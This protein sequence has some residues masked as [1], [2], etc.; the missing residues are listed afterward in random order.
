MAAAYRHPGVYIEE[1]RSGVRAIASVSTSTT[2]FIDYF[3]RGPLGEAV[4]ITSYANF[5]RGFGGLHASSPGSYAIKQFYLNGGHVALVVRV[6]SGTPREAQ[7]G[8]GATAGSATRLPLIVRAIHP[9]TWGNN[10][11]VA[12]DYNTAGGQPN[13]FNL[14]VREVVTVGGRKQV[15]HDEVHRNLSMDTASPRYA[16][17][18]VNSISLLV[19][20][21]EGMGERGVRPDATT[22]AAV[23]DVTQ[24]SI[25]ADPA[26]GEANLGGGYPN[27]CRVFFSLGDSANVAQFSLPAADDGSPPDAAALIA[28][29]SALDG[30]APEIFNLLCLPAAATLDAPSG[31][32]DTPNLRAVVEAAE[33]CCLDGRAFLIVDIPEF[34]RDPADMMKWMAANENF[35]HRNAA[36]YYPRL[37][38]SDPL[39]EGRTRNVGASGTMAGVYAATDT[40][41]GVWKAPAGTDAALQ[42][43]VLTRQIT[44]LQNGVLNPLGI[45]ALRTFPT[46]GTVSWGARTLEGADRL[47]SEWRYI[48]VRRMALFI[49][50]SL[51]QGLK[52][53]VF[54]PNDEPLWG[55]IRLHAGAFMQNLFRQGAFQGSSP[56][57]AYF[58]KCDRETTT[59][60]DIDRG[61]VNVVV[62]FAALKPAEFVVIQIQ[63]IAEQIQT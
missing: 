12:I 3:P 16:V 15:L 54:E 25:L 27:P 29:L 52:W 17:D 5:E 14:V 53:V 18:V 37:L 45:N 23:T 4:R 36:V 48:P 41:R 6:A 55:Q 30:I 39:N 49:E 58:V 22:T 32:F 31:S 20:L 11:Q 60:H 21:A 44:D 50:E 13:E 56:R 33:K 24:A 35:R 57:E 19:R 28:G 1:A 38:T 42:G 7:R 34:V 26:T 46:L 8:L 63:Q 40:A 62:G 61:I 43:A 51:F 47:A 10:L 9:G 59:Q 2:A